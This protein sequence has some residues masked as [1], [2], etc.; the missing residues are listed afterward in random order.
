MLV[1]LLC[2]TAALDGFAQGVVAFTNA[3]VIDGV[4]ERVVEGVTVVVRDGLIES[5][6]TAAIPDGAEV[7]DIEGRYLLPGYIDAHMHIAGIEAAK[8][9]LASAAES[10]PDRSTRRRAAAEVEL[11]AKRA[12]A[13]P[14]D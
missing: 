7:I 1:A 9:A 12:P 14:K 10:H 4:T 11:L 2:C 6:G 13:P 5:V 3:N 8:R